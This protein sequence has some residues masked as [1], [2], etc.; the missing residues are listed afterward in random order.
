MGGFHL[1]TI[2]ELFCH[3]WGIDGPFCSEVEKARAPDSFLLKHVSVSI[4]YF[5]FWFSHRGEEDSR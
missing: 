4:E 3:R 2:N 1:R 5:L